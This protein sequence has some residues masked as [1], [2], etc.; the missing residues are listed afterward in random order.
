MDSAIRRAHA[1]VNAPDGTYRVTDLTKSGLGD[2]V[3]PYFRLFVPVKQSRGRLPTSLPEFQVQRHTATLSDSPVTAA[4][5][6]GGHWTDHNLAAI[7]QVA[8][9][10]LRCSYCYVDFR[11]LA[12]QDS[13]PVTPERLV[14]EFTRLCEY[15]ARKGRRLSILR[16]SGGEPL[17]APPLITQVFEIAADRKLLNS[18]MLKV[19][20][21]MSAFPSA[22]SL[23]GD[24]ERQRF[25]RAAKHIAVHA[26]LHEKPGGHQWPNIRAGLALAVDLG[27]DIYPAIGGT[28]WSDDDL[29]RLFDELERTATGLSARL[30]VR[31]FSLT[32]TER[33]KR[34]RQITDGSESRAPSQRWDDI[35]QDR[36][37][38]SYLERP[39]HLVTLG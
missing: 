6:L 29:H 18:C 28:G 24:V 39:R 21:N 37:N 38:H 4:A 31:P 32:Y 10:N 25:R 22:W 19:E 2:V 34:R 15:V 35:L 17:L 3:N 9:C 20:S 5:H 14:D 1:L 7:T 13:L 23:L 16:I 33:Y 36:T 30:A 8:A 12:G 27:I 11:H 26:T